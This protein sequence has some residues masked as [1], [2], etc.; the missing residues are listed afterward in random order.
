MKRIVVASAG[1]AALLSLADGQAADE[2]TLSEFLTDC[3]RHSQ[4]C[5]ASLTDY[6]RAAS[7]QAMICLP[8][9][10]PVERAAVQ[11]LDWLR[12]TG[13]R[14]ETL[15]QGNVE[16]AEWTAISTLWPCAAQN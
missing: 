3:N 13:A 11:A 5:S 10:L 8:A 9:D 12:H 15:S 2:R 7:E 1:I 6:V 4:E 16:D 14:D